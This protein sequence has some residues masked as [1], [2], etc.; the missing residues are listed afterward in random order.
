MEFILLALP[1]IAFLTLV[2]SI[3]QLCRTS[4]GNAARRKSLKKRIIISSI[5][6]LLWLLAV[7]GFFFLIMYSIAVHGM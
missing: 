4:K 3:I 2:I 1:V 6:I 7:G 5:I